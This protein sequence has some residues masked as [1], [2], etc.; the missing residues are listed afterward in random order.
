VQ[1][2]SGLFFVIVIFLSAGFYLRCHTGPPYQEDSD[3]RAIERDAD[4]NR[5]NLALTG[6]DLADGV[7]R[8]DRQTAR[9]KS[10]LEG[11][12][13]AIDGS[14]LEDSEKET[15]LTHVAVVQK[16]TAALRC[17]VITLRKAAERLNNQLAEQREISATLSV[18]YDRR[19]AA[20]TE[21]KVELEGT[22]EELAKVRGQRNLYLAIFIAVCLGILGYIAFRVLRF[23][24]IIPV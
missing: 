23:L 19:E 13:V 8:I 24:R 12:G 18:E 16:E 17:E 6:T 1:R 14:G 2:K 5:I 22:K 11:L 21:V 3:Y 15:L 10:E 7:E 20:G 9:I 4:R